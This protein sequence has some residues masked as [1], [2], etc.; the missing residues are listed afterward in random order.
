MRISV[1]FILLFSKGLENKAR[2]HLQVG[3]E[4]QGVWHRL[5]APA[6]GVEEISP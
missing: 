1:A 6:R 5:Y 4:H 3:R 2:R